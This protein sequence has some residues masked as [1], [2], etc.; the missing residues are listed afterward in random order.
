MIMSILA[1]KTK[2]SSFVAIETKHEFDKS[3]I[4]LLTEIVIYTIY[5][6][7]KEVKSCNYTVESPLKCGW[8]DNEYLYSHA[9]TYHLQG[10]GL[11]K[12]KTWI[13]KGRLMQ[14]PR[15]INI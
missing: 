9:L 6:Q 8:L 5:Y 4:S 13:K 12:C 14:V 11:I 15:L 7:Y 3:S 10:Y 1:L 2:Y